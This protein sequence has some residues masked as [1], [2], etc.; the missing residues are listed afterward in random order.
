[1]QHQR[2]EEKVYLYGASV[3]I[4]EGLFVLNDPGVRDLLDL[5]IFVQADSDLMLA[6]RIIRDT[7]E[8]G[9]DVHGIIDHYLRWVKVRDSGR[10]GQQLSE[11]DVSLSASD[12]RPWTIT[13]IQIASGPIL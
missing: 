11:A 7:K 9:R 12:S 8:R 6:R 10:C 1:M 4:V 3:I 2:T 13:S 5:K